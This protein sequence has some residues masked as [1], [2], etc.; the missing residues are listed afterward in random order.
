MITSSLKKIHAF[1]K[2]ADIR[3]QLRQLARPPAL[4]A[5]TCRSAHLLWKAIEL[6]RNQASDAALQQTF[7]REE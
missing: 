7:Y 1:Q 3:A 4:V 2:T 5:G 6:Y